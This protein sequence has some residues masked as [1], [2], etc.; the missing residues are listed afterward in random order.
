MGR[1]VRLPCRGSAYAGHQDVHAH[2]QRARPARAG[3]RRPAAGARRRRPTSARELLTE[4]GHRRRLRRGGDRG[5]AAAAV[6]RAS[7]PWRHSC[8]ARCSSSCCR[9]S[10]T[11]PRDAPRPSSSSSCRCSCCCRP[12][13]S[14]SWWRA[15]TSPARSA[16]PSAATARRSPSRSPRATPGTR[17]AP[18]SPSASCTAGALSW[19]DAPVFA[20]ALAAQIAIDFVLTAVRLRVGM[21]M[22]VRPELP[23]MGWVY[24]VDVL[25]TPIGVLAAVAGRG[26][27]AAVRS[28]CR[29]RRSSSCSPASGADASRTHSPCSRVADENEQRLQS[30]VQHASDLILIAERDGTVRSLTGAAGEHFGAGW[31][32]VTGTTLF[33]HAHPADHSVVSALLDAAVRAARGES[34]EAEWRMRRPDGSWRHVEGIATNLLDEAHLEALVVT[35]RDVHERRV[36]EEQLRHRAFHDELTGLPNRALFHDRLEH[37]LGQRGDRLVAP[38]LRGPRRLQED[39]RPPR[40]R[41]RRRAAHRV[42]RAAAQLRAVRRHA[43]AARR[44]RV[45]RPARGRRGTERAGARRRADRRGAGRAADRGRR[46]LRGH[47]EHRDRRQHARRRRARRAAPPRRPRHVRREGRG[48]GPLGALRARARRRPQRERRRPPARVLGDALRRAARADPLAPGPSRRGPDRLPAD[49]RS[50]H[51]RGR[52]VRGAQPLRRA[53]RPSARTSGSSRRTGA[54]SATGSRRSP[55]SA[56]SALPD[57]PTAPI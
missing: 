10:S 2:A 56:P 1:R 7:P 34:A 35:V 18:R 23:A 39:Q 53:G 48:E 4:L 3:L 30:L 26:S 31:R 42:R 47:V 24:L 14:R 5:R 57:G 21:G 22:P 37:A 15:R 49:H 16:G 55:S 44:R 6:G 43:R 54:A 38:R 52:G 8:S 40:P 32:E 33:D 27:L 45:R 12:R 41:R 29:W 36:F 11:S 20:A 28:S 51:R 19:S 13:S 9:S 17:S 50:A 25:L 46:E